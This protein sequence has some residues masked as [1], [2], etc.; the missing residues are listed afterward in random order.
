MSATDPFPE[1]PALIALDWGTSNLRASLLDRQGRALQQRQ[2]AGG[3][4]AVPGG[5]FEPALLALCGDWLARHDVPLIASGMIGSRQG[6]REAPYM[7]CPAS[8]AQAAAQRVT[9]R[10]ASGRTLHILPGLR[11]QSDDGEW[12]VMRGEE[13]QLWGAELPAGA[14]AVLPGTHSKWAWMGRGGEIRTFRTYMTG[15]LYALCTQH[16]ILGRLMEFG[17]D[18][19]A[20]FDAGVR[21]GLQAPEQTT[22]MLFAARTA[23]LMGRV[24]A[25]GLPDFLSGMLMGIEIAGARLCAAVQGEVVLIGEEA[26]CRRYGRALDL[27]GLGSRQAGTQATLRGQWRLA[28]AAGL[29]DENRMD[30]GADT[31][32][33]A[34]PFIQPDS[35][36]IAT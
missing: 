11:V 29:T 25:T 17:H 18:S 13:T 21:R 31:P 34:Q 12:D 16:G 28:R 2:S 19:P 33:V 22:H 26:L 10:L 20:D 32:G 6:W 27:A 30:S 3:V 5:A 23:G 14:C 24:S 4:M 8:L 9:V 1:A 7:D 36:G 15:E 35:T